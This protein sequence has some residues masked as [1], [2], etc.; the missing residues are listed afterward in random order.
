MYDI[1]HIDG[2]RATY[3]GFV[4]CTIKDLLDYLYLIYTQVTTLDIKEIGISMRNL[5]NPPYTIEII[6]KQISDEIFTAAVLH[7][8]KCK[9]Y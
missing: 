2:I 3:V 9:Y 8:E 5:Y 1:M 6:F 4:T 7:A